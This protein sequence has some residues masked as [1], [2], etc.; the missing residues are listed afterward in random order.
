MEK[1]ATPAITPRKKT[2][3]KRNA[4]FIFVKLAVMLPHYLNAWP[5]RIGRYGKVV[6]NGYR[7]ITEM[8]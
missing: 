6:L 3:T 2:P 8:Q 1:N 5:S 4:F 7:F